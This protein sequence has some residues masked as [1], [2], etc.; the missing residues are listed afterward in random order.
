MLD[1]LGYC[2][3]CSATDVRLAADWEQQI[4]QALAQADWFAVVLSPDAVK[5]EWVQAEVHWALRTSAVASSPSW[6][7]PASPPTRTCVSARSSSWTSA[8]IR[9]RRSGNWAQ[10]IP[11]RGARQ[12]KSASRIAPPQQLEQMTVISKRREASVR[13]RIETADGATREET[14]KIQNSAV[15]GRTADADLTLRDDYV[16]RKHARIAVVPDLHGAHLT[17][18]DLESANGTLLN[19]S[20]VVTEQPLAVGDRIDVGNTRVVV[21]SI[22]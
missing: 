20:G 10:L 17:L 5:S 2:S 4:R 15:V 16:S 12:A 6:P 11:G 18:M 14:L 7:A 1:Q 22:D 19:G 8:R 9:P 3:W 13:L 21:L